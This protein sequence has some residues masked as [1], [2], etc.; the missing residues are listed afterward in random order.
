MP[1][2]FFRAVLFYT[3]TGR[4]VLQARVVLEGFILRNT[5][6]QVLQTRFYFT[7]HRKTGLTDQNCSR[8]LYF[9]IHRKSGFIKAFVLIQH[10]LQ[11][12]HEGVFAVAEFDQDLRSHSS[13]PYRDNKRRNICFWYNS[14]AIS[15]SRPKINYLQGSQWLVLT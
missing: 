8:G 4:Q 7:I 2:L 10:R 12:Q 13:R 5:G 15:T 9:K 14:S 6:R 1:E 11:S 3:Y